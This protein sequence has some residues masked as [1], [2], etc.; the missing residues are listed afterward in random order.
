MFSKS[1][2]RVFTK[3]IPC[4]CPP[5]PEHPFFMNN[6]ESRAGSAR[7]MF[8]HLASSSSLIQKLI[9]VLEKEGSHICIL[10]N[11]I[12]NNHAIKKVTSI[13]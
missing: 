2:N 5:P 7:Q 4:G 6:S 8:D 3:N 1:L 9:Y 12:F 13:S 11:I 10:T